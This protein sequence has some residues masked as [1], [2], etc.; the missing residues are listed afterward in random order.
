MFFVPA[1]NMCSFS[2]AM[3]HRLWPLAKQMSS[4]PCSHNKTCLVSVLVTMLSRMLHLQ[5]QV[6]A[7]WS[8]EA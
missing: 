6:L 1:G 5:K 4:S 8:I 7:Q 3:G 2:V